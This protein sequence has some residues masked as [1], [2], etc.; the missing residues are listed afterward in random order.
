MDPWVWWVVA[1]AVL[2]VFEVV[3]GG[4]LVFLM[5]AAGALVAG[6]VSGLGGGS[7]LAV[8]AFAAVSAV[9]LLGVRPLAR[10]HRQVLPR[11]R[12][13]IA[14]LIGTDAIV[15][16]EVGPDCGLVKIGGE[17]WTAR[18]YDGDSVYPIG[19]RVSVLKIAGA[20]ALVAQ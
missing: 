15:E 13:G 6:V 18:P 20:T 17:V 3:S 2:G 11:D 7:L 16:A 5:L 1:A 4:T 12:M 19:E 9:S 10:R 8:G 14:A